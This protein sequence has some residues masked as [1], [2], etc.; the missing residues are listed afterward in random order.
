[1]TDFSWRWSH[2][3][4][5]LSHPTALFGM[6]MIVML[7]SG[8]GLQIVREFQA[9][10][11]ETSQRLSN[12]A[13]A[14]EEHVSHTIRE[15]DKAL[16]VAISRFQRNRATQTYSTAIS[17]PLLDPAQ[18]SDMG[19]NLAMFDKHGA[20]AATTLT[21]QPSQ[22]I[23]LN[24]RARFMARQSQPFD[25]Q[26]LSAPVLSR[27]SGDWSIDLA[28]RVADIDG[29][30]GGIIMA[31]ID[32]QYFATLEDP[33]KI[34]QGAT[35]V[36][37]GEDGIIRATTGSSAPKLGTSIQATDLMDAKRQSNSVYI[38]YPDGA[39]RKQF[40]ARR[41][42][43]NQRLFVSVSV[44]Q[45]VV[46]AAAYASA[47]RNILACG[48]MTLLILVAIGAGILHHHRLE[49]ARLALTESE[50]YAQR[51]TQE[52]EQTL[53]NM[54]QGII[55]VDGDHKIVVTNENFMRLLDLPND[56]NLHNMDFGHL[57]DHLTARGEYGALAA[58]EYDDLAGKLRATEF[59]GIN[60]NFERIR[61]NGIVLAIE[62]QEL[63]DGGF[64]RTVTD[65]TEKRRS[66]RQ[67]AHLARHDTLTNLANRSLF[68]DKLEEAFASM[69]QTGSFGVL[70]LDLDN[71]KIANDTYGH[72]FGD[73]L[74]KAVGNRLRTSTRSGDT[75]ARLG[76]DEFAIILNGLNKSGRIAKRAHQLIDLMRAPFM[77]EGQQIT[78]TISVGCAEAPSDAG[79]PGE[80]LKNAD[81]ALYKAKAEGRNTYRRFSPEMADEM[82][83][84]R[85]L[86]DD[87]RHAIAHDEFELNYQP[88]NTISS[89]EIS[90]FEALLRWNHPSQ[91]RVP[92]ADFIPIAE[93]GGLILAIGEWVLGEA[94]KQA[95]RWDDNIRIAVNLSPVQFH[96]AEL[97]MKVEYALQ[98]SGLRPNRLELEITESVM[99]QTG[100]LAI[101]KLNELHQIG[102]KISMDDFGTG[103]SSL[104]YLKTFSFDKIKIDR[105]FVN[106]IE[107]D[108]E[109]RAIIK[110][111]ISLADGLGIRTTAEGVENAEQ[112]GI[113]TQLGC[114][115]A[116]G[117]LFSPPRPLK[118]VPSLIDR[119][120][121]LPEMLKSVSE[122]AQKNTVSHSGK[123]AA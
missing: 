6:A 67:I 20:L 91:G 15:Q 107:T 45:T 39:G 24:G 35:I 7:W 12:L 70:F 29:T 110:A 85:R 104:S 42:I 86:E 122:K 47:V 76:G 78:A 82:N 51:K 112:L 57:I 55:M 14:F 36:L 3:K 43:P 74:L 13:R 113:L 108:N 44:P 93:D 99:M 50:A 80:I 52:L 46:Y 53:D 25:T 84:R 54:G 87:L 48:G 33:I 34:N 98:S 88:L 49:R 92:P 83:K 58:D 68:R 95:A 41:K 96:D 118:D 19:F 72:A 94:C 63:P 37:A 16:R 100:K 10:R 5:H 111:I 27:R 59:N 61:P 17:Q 30:F 2:I 22:R 102:V 105:S 79:S 23:E 69:P 121:L 71:F 11:A 9:A 38:G 115:E 101:D 26:Y 77:I 1:M 32:P 106:Q 81:L 103:Y 64:V 75:V 117:Y 90:G 116:Q 65:I 97:I 56:I 8:S 109:S 73:E 18:I 66:E 40:Y 89:G 4:K 31:S 28:R 60:A 21:S 123:S 114:W 119:G 120:T 62:N